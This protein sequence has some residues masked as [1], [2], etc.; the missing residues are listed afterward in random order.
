MCDEEISGLVVARVRSPNPKGEDGQG[1][2][3][4]VRGDAICYPEQVKSRNP[5]ER[6]DLKKG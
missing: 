5:R 1:G 6:N 2:H 3:L 4:G